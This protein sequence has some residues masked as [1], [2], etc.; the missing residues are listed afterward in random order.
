MHSL[1]LFFSWS[2]LSTTSFILI[3]LVGSSSSHQDRFACDRSFAYDPTRF[4]DIAAIDMEQ[5]PNVGHPTT[6]VDVQDA[7]RARYVRQSDLWLD[8]LLQASGIRS[9]HQP[10][11]SVDSIRLSIPPS[12]TP[13]PFVFWENNGTS[14]VNHNFMDFLPTSLQLTILRRHAATRSGPTAPTPMLSPT[15]H[16]IP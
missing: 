15:A 7:I 14:S 9:F 6:T 8:P 16:S 5:V 10:V 12:A 4:F 13:H 2:G 1:C 3:K 11:S